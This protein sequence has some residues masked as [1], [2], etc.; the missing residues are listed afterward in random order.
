MPEVAAG[1]GHKVPPRRQM[2]RV[3]KSLP[4]GRQGDDDE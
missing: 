4:A 1:T 3:L 2:G